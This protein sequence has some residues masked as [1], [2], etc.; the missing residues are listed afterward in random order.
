MTFNVLSFLV[1][2]VAGIPLAY[3]M[4]HW[5]KG[6]RKSRSYSNSELF[7]AVFR[8]FV[9]EVVERVQFTSS[10]SKRYPPGWDHD[11]A[12]L[13]S[14][15][16]RGKIISRMDVFA[17]LGKKIC[18]MGR[19]CFDQHL[20]GEYPDHTFWPEAFA[21]SLQNGEFSEEE[22]GKIRFDH[23]QTVETFIKQCG[24]PE[25]IEKCYRRLLPKPRTE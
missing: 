9:L 24:D 2:V 8:D 6:D 20:R 7:L 1:G 15:A 5:R 21:Y 17:L 18:R 12:K 25:L 3:G 14:F 13:L 23:E 16:I 19:S 10:C 4:S 22:V 11:L